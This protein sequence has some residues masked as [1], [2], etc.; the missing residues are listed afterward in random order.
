MRR[1]VTQ[2]RTEGKRM[3]KSRAS[4]SA[5]TSRGSAISRMPPR[6]PGRIGDPLPR[7]DRGRME[8]V[9]GTQGAPSWVERGAPT[10]PRSIR[11]EAA[12][13]SHSSSRTTWEGERKATEE[14]GT[15]KRD[16]DDERE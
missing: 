15:P 4:Q 16:R 11:E 1:R 6:T 3:K 7:G 5:E 8:R 10:P 14:L 2:R 9:G 12:S 13:D